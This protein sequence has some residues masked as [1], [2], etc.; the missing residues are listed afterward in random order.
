MR[1]LWLMAGLGF[2][3]A[4]GGCTC[5]GAPASADAGSAAASASGAP[6][7]KPKVAA[8][9]DHAIERAVKHLAGKIDT[10]DPRIALVLAYPQRKFAPAGL[11]S[12]VER[13]AAADADPAQKH[14]ADLFRRLVDGSAS[15]D[16]QSIEA[17]PS[18]IDRMNAL[19]LYCDR[20]GKPDALLP[21]L[22]SETEG[23]DPYSLPHAMMATGL[24][25]EN[26]CLAD[27]VGQ[28]LR[29]RQAELVET[30]LAAVTDSRI[31]DADIEAI[32]FL[33]YIG[34]GAHVKARWIET[35]VD[36][37][38]PSGGWSNRTD[39]EEDHTT[40]LALWLLLEAAHPDAPPVGWIPRQVSP[41]R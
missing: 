10:L 35:I 41:P 5:S 3:V 27:D 37:Q 23:V 34:R 17:E 30:R 19:A 40:A 18:A 14:F 38:L 26:G 7:F 4:I 29:D 39:E 28:L 9:I 15:V 6:R 16:R 25:T 8:R 24:A 22:T 33:Y 2:A 1:R 11:P 20:L 36:E 21:Q 32:L 13:S 12:M 31:R